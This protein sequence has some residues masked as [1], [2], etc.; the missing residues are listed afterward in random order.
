MNRRYDVIITYAQMLE[1]TRDLAFQV[2]KTAPF[3]AYLSKAHPLAQKRPP[4]FIQLADEP[5]YVAAHDDNR[6]THNLCT[7]ICAAHG[8]RPRII[9]SVPNVESQM[10]AVRLGQGVALLTTE[11]A[12]PNAS[13]FLSIP[14]NTRADIVLAWRKDIESTPV[15]GVIQ[16]FLRHMTDREGGI[17]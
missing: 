11:V 6:M 14:T 5:F 4:S 9:K 7:N 1:E 13:C 10:M 16:D 12:I 2:L 3:V 8:F 17:L 15:S